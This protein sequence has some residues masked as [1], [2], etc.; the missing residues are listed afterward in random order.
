MFSP[1][2]WN[3]QMESK[4]C[5]NPRIRELSATVPLPIPHRKAAAFVLSLT[6]NTI[7]NWWLQMQPA[8]TEAF[9]N[10]RNWQGNRFLM[11]WEN[12]RQHWQNWEL[13]KPLQMKRAARPLQTFIHPREQYCR[14]QILF[15]SWLHSRIRWRIV[16]PN[17]RRLMCR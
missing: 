2:I 16:S 5:V 15:Q 1:P 14:T 3:L 6:E 13:T 4:H 8:Q 17:R 12:S 7:M 10:F 11:T 9:P